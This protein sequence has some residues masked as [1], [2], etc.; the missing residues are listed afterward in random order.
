M[1]PARIDRVTQRDI[2]KARAADDAYGREARLKGLLRMCRAEQRELARHLG[3]TAV[4]PV[5]I[6]DRAAREM[7]VCIDEPGEHRLARQIDHR[8]AG[9]HRDV[10]SDR[11]DA[12]PLHQDHRVFHR[13]R[14]AAVD[15]RARANRRDCRSLLEREYRQEHDHETSSLSFPRNPPPPAPPASPD[16]S[17]EPVSAA[18][19]SSAVV[20]RSSGF[21]CSAL[22][23]ARST[24]SGTSV[25]SVRIAT[26][27]LRSRA[28]IISCALRPWKGSLPVNISNATI[29]RA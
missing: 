15:E 6:A 17:A 3:Q 9:R 14:A 24:A 11:R 16:E 4:L 8:R 27:W 21:V 1:Y 12:I 20:K 5:A 25:R 26:G 28:I 23:S 29:P 10:R 7:H 19:N 18:P 2:A 13:R 22:V